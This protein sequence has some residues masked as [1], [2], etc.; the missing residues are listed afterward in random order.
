MRTRFTYAVLT[1]DQ[2]A[3]RVAVADHLIRKYNYL[4][5]YIDAVTDICLHLDFVAFDKLVDYKLSV[6]DISIWMDRYVMETDTM[7]SASMR[8][9]IFAD[10]YLQQY[11]SDEC[12]I[13]L[14]LAVLCRPAGTKLTSD[15]NM[16][17]RRA[18]MYRRHSRCIIHG[19][20]IRYAAVAAF[21]LILHT[22]QHV[23]QYYMPH[24]SDGSEGP[25]SGVN[26][27]WHNV[28]M[29]I[30][31]NGAFGNIEDS[32]NASFHDVMTFCIKKKQ[33]ADRA[34]LAARKK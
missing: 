4:P 10:D 13:Y 9:Y 31:E 2:H 21:L 6:S 27:G 20:A 25:A 34:E 14:L 33:D 8:C 24:L 7:E 19:A 23:D 11:L 18:E 28:A 12:D 30:G 15:R 1:H 26:F 22:K 3:I 32:Y 16:I 5:G 29:D 17:V